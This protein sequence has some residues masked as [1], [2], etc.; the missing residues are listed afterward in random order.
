MSII[1]HFRNLEHTQALDEM[2]DKKTAKLIR[3]LGVNAQFEWICWI[4]KESHCSELKIKNRKEHFIAK[5]HADNLYKS[6]DLIVEKIL[7]QIK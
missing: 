1:K 4:E 6:F 3:H 7:N 2:I 5:A